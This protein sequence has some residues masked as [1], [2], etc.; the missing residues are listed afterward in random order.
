MEHFQEFM[1]LILYFTC[2]AM[3][4]RLWLK[5]YF[6]SNIPENVKPKENYINYES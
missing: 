5:F 6:L 2:K 4:F 3:V 1:M